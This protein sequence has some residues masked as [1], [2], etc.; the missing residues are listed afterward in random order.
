[1][2]DAL[3]VLASLAAVVVIAYYRI[4]WAGGTPSRWHYSIGR[5]HPSITPDGFVKDSA[6]L[7]NGQ[8]RAA[9]T[10]SASSWSSSNVSSHAMHGSVML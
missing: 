4:K 6:V 7:Q 2:K 8:R 5:K 1:M 3:I 10:V 9:R